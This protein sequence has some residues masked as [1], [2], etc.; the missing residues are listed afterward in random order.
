[1]SRVLAPVPV[2]R[3]GVSG[4]ALALLCKPVV[5]VTAVQSM[6][7]N[8]TANDFIMTSHAESVT[9]RI[10]S[11]KNLTTNA[12]TIYRETTVSQ[13]NVQGV[14]VANVRRELMPTAQPNF[15]SSDRVTFRHELTMT[16]AGYTLMLRHEV[17]ALVSEASR[18]KMLADQ[19]RAGNYNLLQSATLCVRLSGTPS[20]EQITQAIDMMDVGGQYGRIVQQIGQLIGRPGNTLKR[21]TNAP[22][23]LDRATYMEIF[24]PHDWYATIKSEGLHAVVFINHGRMH[25]VT[26][27]VVTLPTSH[28]CVC[29]IEGEL[30]SDESAHALPEPTA[31]TITRYTFRAFDVLVSQDR[32]VTGEPTS[33]RLA[34]LDAAVGMC[35]PLKATAKSMQHFTTADDA[36]VMRARFDSIW[37]AVYRA[38]PEGIILQ[39]NASYSEMII[40]KW[41]PVTNQTIDFMVRE[42]PASAQTRV[43]AHLV[44]LY[45]G[46]DPRVMHQLGLQVPAHMRQAAG[47]AHHH[48]RRRGPPAKRAEYQAIPFMPVYAPR[49]YEYWMPQDVYNRALAEHAGKTLDGAIVE[50][51]HPDGRWQFIRVRTDRVTDVQAGRYFGNDFRIAENTY[52][53]IVNPLRYEDLWSIDAGYFREVRNETYKAQRAYN[54]AVKGALTARYCHGASSVVELAGGR[55]ADMANY[56]K[57]Q[58][59]HVTYVDNDR[60]AL[61]T[62]LQRRYT[63]RLPVP[64]S[65]TSAVYADL[66]LDTALDAISDVR[67]QAGLQEA[68]VVACH[69]AIHYFVEHLPAFAAIVATLVQPGGR[70]MCTAFNG[71]R[72]FELLRNHAVGESWQASEPDGDVKY[73]VRRDFTESTLLPHGQRIAVRLPFSRGELYPEWLCNF[74]YVIESFREHGFVVELHT[75]F[76]D[77][78]TIGLHRA[79]AW[80]ACS[81]ADKHWVGMC[82]VLVMRKK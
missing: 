44:W 56:A 50:L 24:P 22:R 38:A 81:D 78:A 16:V 21:V 80:Q 2:K 42:P 64:L 9:V 34:L 14:Q 45:C 37:R 30:E 49:A 65:C 58:V 19:I 17:H 8:A 18:V 61:S 72:L 52:D 11:S 75:S 71:A 54:A 36:I 66:T 70:F 67:N 13:R 47:G 33:A 26:S 7:K 69:F 1:M 77:H 27:N 79:D 4:E 40:Y 25:I 41:K 60:D 48:D 53:V 39:N 62:L 46:I 59:G 68:P 5:D 15:A 3:A 74:D 55:G 10:I 76:A 51:S 28:D 6:F 23:S 35:A 29:V 12:R 43:D 82:D 31:D 73:E 57:A 20:D 32:D 63:S